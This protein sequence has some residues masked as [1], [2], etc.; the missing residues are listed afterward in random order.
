MAF[1]N[2]G[3][4]QGNHKPLSTYSSPPRSKRLCIVRAL[5]VVLRRPITWYLCPTYPL[6]KRN[7]LELSSLQIAVPHLDREDAPLSTQ[8]KEVILYFK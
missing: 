1:L 3:L 2:A 8:K 7:C 6:D 5:F 4:A